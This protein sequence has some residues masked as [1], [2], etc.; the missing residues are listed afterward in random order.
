MA[1]KFFC[2]VDESGQDTQGQLFIVSVLVTDNDRERLRQLCEDIERRSGKGERK[3]SKTSGA[4]RVNYIQALLE[5]K[6]VAG[7]L[8]YQVFEGVED[9]LMA[10]VEAIARV[11]EI[12]TTDDYDATILIDGLSRSLE[13]GVGLDLRRLGAHV[14][15]VRG[16]DEDNDALMRLADAVCGL[17]RS[18]LEGDPLLRELW[19]QGVQAGLLRDLSA[20]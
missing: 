8:H 3:W 10:T 2:Y 14:K 15:K 20:K 4:R 18:G 12:N 17:V 11:L 1:T 7:K 6:V 5:Q 16:L 19:L 9:Y 13:R